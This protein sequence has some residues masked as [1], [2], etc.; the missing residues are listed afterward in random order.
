MIVSVPGAALASMMASRKLQSLASPLRKRRRIGAGSFVRV[1]CKSRIG[2]RHQHGRR[3][4]ALVDRQHSR[5]V[6]QR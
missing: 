3:A 6:R 2:Q 1:H 5:T 4:L